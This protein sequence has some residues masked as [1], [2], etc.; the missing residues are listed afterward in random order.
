M[1]LAHKTVKKSYNTELTIICVN[2]F[3]QSIKF[4][5]LHEQFICNTQKW[6]WVHSI[7]SF[8]PTIDHERF[9]I[10]FNVEKDIFPLQLITIMLKTQYTDFRISCCKAVLK[11]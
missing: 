11:K 9:S 5:K 7:P 8:W 3:I 1:S 2:D 10:V 6:Q 4:K